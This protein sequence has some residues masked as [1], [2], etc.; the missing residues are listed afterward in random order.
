MHKSLGDLLLER[1]AFFPTQQ[2]CPSRQVYDFAVL[3]VPRNLCTFDLGE[4]DSPGAIKHPQCI[5]GVGIGVGRQVFA[6]N[7]LNFR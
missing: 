6:T 2:Q 1:L 3:F 4:A 7:L 5:A